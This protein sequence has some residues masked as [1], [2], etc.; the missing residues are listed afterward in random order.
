[1]NQTKGTNELIK[2]TGELNDQLNRMG[3]TRSKT[4]MAK[5]RNVTFRPP[6]RTARPRGDNG[7]TEEGGGGRV[8]VQEAGEEQMRGRQW[9]RG[10]KKKIGGVEGG[11]SPE[12]DE[13]PKTSQ[14]EAPGR[15]RGREEP[16]W[17]RP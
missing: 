3:K 16:G 10:R 7:P 9:E 13:D 4:D 2:T 12:P 11:R 17:R 15:S 5:H 6:P 8:G 14:D 1:M